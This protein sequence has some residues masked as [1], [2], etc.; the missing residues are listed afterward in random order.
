MPVKELQA[1]C[2]EVFDKRGA[3]GDQEPT[4]VAGVWANFQAASKT[5][6]FMAEQGGPFQ[7]TAPDGIQVAVGRNTTNSSAQWSPRTPPVARIAT[8]CSPLKARPNEAFN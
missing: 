5:I 1:V 6:F 8:R 4:G 7:G 3:S 2:D